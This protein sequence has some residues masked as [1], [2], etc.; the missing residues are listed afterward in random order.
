M[1][2][3]GIVLQKISPTITNVYV[4]EGLFGVCLPA[5]VITEGRN[6]ERIIHIRKDCKGL[7]PELEHAVREPYRQRRGNYGV[8]M[9]AFVG[10]EM[11]YSNVPIK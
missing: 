9:T 4:V 7:L 6:D 8:R 10:S 3:D 5:G 1:E 2:N 11:L